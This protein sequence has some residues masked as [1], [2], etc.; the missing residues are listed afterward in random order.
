VLFHFGVQRLSGGFVGVD[1]FFVISG[2]LITGIILREMGKGTFGIVDFYDRRIRRIFPALITVLAACLFVSFC[3]DLP[4]SIKGTSTASIATLFFYSNFYFNGVSDYF[5]DAIKL[6]PLL[7]T[8]SL[9]VEEQFYV[10]F[11]LL[12]FAMR[13][14]D[15]NRKLFILAS[16]AAVSLTWSIWLVHVDTSAG[17]YLPQSRAWE[18]MLGSILTLGVIPEVRGWKA[19]VTA[20]AGIIL[21]LGSAALLTENST[22]PGVGALAPCI[23]AA[24]IIYSGTGRST[25]VGR[26]LSTRPMVGVGLISYSMY[27]WHWPMVAFY[28][29]FYGEPSRLSKVGLIVAVVAISAFS[30][31]YIE[32]PF[33]S[34]PHL[35]APR[36]TLLAG[37]FATA[38]LVLAVVTL[39]PVALIV[40]Q[41][42]T[43]VIAV[44]GYSNYDST[45]YFRSGQCFLSSR[46]NDFNSFDMEKCLHIKQ[47]ASNVLLIGDSHAA[48]LWIGLST[49][50]PE[51]NFLQATSSGC[52]PVLVPSGAKRCTDLINMVFRDFLPKHHVDSVILSASWAEA[53]LAEIEVTVEFLHKFANRIFVIGPSPSYRKPLPAILARQMLDGGQTIRKELMQRDP[54]LIDKEFQT[55]LVHDALTY[56]SLYKAICPKECLLWAGKNQPLLFDSSHFTKSGSIRVAEIIGPQMFRS[57]MAGNDP[58][59]GDIKP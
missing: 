15:R 7:H 17:F 50:Y 34:K 4:S 41:I 19:E 27:L 53:D 37:G 1:V 32:R 24:A 23:G 38:V 12:A 21:I 57:G 39:L 35:L 42:P 14:F 2:Y 45:R 51:I 30:L 43:D 44:D 55:R 47:A 52:M 25:I 6:N 36:Q 20:A 31:K 29:A 11:P 33:R 56:I 48:H 40:R 9:S 16:I 59:A 8:W 18:L 22:F 26:I 3:F 46:F 28:R 54:V 13:T 49:R 58:V 10:L 5:D